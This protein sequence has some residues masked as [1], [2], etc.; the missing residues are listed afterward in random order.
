MKFR[1]RTQNQFLFTIFAK[2]SQVSPASSGA[3]LNRV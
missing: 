3:G 1:A 2:E